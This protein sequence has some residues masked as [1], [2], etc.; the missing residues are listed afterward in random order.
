[1]TEL[2]T[3]NT[4]DRQT[5]Q[6]YQRA[7]AMLQ[8]AQ[9]PFLVGGTFAF[10][11]YTGIVRKTKDLDLFVRSGD[12]ERCLLV[13]AEAGYRTE[14]TIPHWL[15]KASDEAQFIDIIFSS[16]NGIGTVDDEWFT[17][18]VEQTILDMPVLLC[19]RE[20]MIWDKAF[21]MERERYDGADVA[22]LLRGALE[23]L[24]WSRLLRRFH[25]HWRVLFSHLTLFGFIYPD[26]R[27]LIPDWVMHDLVVRLWHEQE[28]LANTA[29]LCRGTL[30]SQTQYMPDLKEWGYRDARHDPFE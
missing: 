18:A 14:L 13:L 29:Q 30:L 16:D 21:I 23:H 3:Q 8:M 9:V 6:F 20:E 11:Y 27:T 7:I 15:G 26:E 17:Y 4:L 24:D 10:A 1:M 12:T 19:P 5:Y 28:N 2:S 22:H 25:P